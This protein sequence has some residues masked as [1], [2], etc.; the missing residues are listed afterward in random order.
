LYRL[1]VKSTRPQAALSYRNLDPGFELSPT[2][3]LHLILLMKD[4]RRAL[5][6]AAT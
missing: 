5:R 2:D 3:P 4:L 6:D 1:A